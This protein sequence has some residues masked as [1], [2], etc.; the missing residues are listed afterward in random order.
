MHK[1]ATILASALLLGYLITEISFRFF[2]QNF[3]AL[4]SI[5]VLGFVVHGFF[6]ARQTQAMK[7]TASP[8]RDQ[9]KAQGRGNNRPKQNRGGNKNRGQ[10]RD[11]HADNRQDQNRNNNARKPQ[12]SSGPKEEGEVKW[13]NRTKGY[14]FIIRPNTEEI[15]VHQRSIVSDDPQSRP[16]LHDGERVAYVVSKTDR[17][18]QAE[19]VVPL[20]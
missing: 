18:A 20:G 10:R 6:I 2:P 1:T 13:F 15:F 4:L 9:S 19:Q 8:N 17:G 16:T 12:A 3:M 5:A 7:E 11:R 14:G